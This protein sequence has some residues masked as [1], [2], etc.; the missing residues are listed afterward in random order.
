MATL[1]Q[2]IPKKTVGAEVA[3]AGQRWPKATARREGSEATPASSL[4]KSGLYFGLEV[5]SEG[6]EQII[7]IR[8]IFEQHFHLKHERRNSVQ[9]IR[10]HPTTTPAAH[11]DIKQLPDQKEKGGHRER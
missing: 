6:F 1:S 7:L 3:T 2:K 10:P 9:K 11:F 4:Y 5:S 8:S